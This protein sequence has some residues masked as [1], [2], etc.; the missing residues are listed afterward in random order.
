LT[1]FTAKFPLQMVFY[2]MDLF[3]SQ[4]LYFN[5]SFI[6]PSI[7]ELLIIKNEI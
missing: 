2:V 4:V 5:F 6:I 1:L 7:F 3:L